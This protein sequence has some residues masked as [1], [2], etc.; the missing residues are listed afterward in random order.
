VAVLVVEQGVVLAHRLTRQA[1]PPSMAAN[2][3][4]LGAAKVV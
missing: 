3:V 1:V 2:G 4:T